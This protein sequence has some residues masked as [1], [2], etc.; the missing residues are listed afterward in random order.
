MSLLSLKLEELVIH[1]WNKIAVILNFTSSRRRS[2]RP[3]VSPIVH[4]LLFWQ[5]EDIPIIVTMVQ[6]HPSPRLSAQHSAAASLY[7]SLCHCGYA[8]LTQGLVW[9]FAILTCYSLVFSL[10]RLNL[11]LR[12]RTEDVL[13][14]LLLVEGHIAAVSFFERTK[15]GY[16]DFR[17]KRDFIILTFQL[18]F[19]I[20]RAKWPWNLIKVILFCD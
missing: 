2:R 12:L 19:P 13:P 8:R 14:P 11:R 5:S 9:T 1:G 10:W 17:A 15:M 20:F 4:H 6:P 3:F 7:I 18:E 16:V